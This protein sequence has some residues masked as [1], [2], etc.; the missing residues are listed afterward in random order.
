[1]EEVSLQNCK[2]GISIFQERLL[3]ITSCLPDVYMLLGGDFNA[4]TGTK[5][6]FVED[7]ML[8]YIETE[9][10]SLRDFIFDNFTLQRY[11]VDKCVN[12]FW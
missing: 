6:D 4:R 3:E 2:N 12:S 10:H 11:S 8:E 5:P 7:D 9:N 1:M